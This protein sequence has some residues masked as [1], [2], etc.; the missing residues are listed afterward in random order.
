MTENTTT[1]DEIEQLPDRIATT[2]NNRTVFVTGGSGF[3]GKVLVEKILRKC[4]RVK[5]IYLLLRV[6]KGKAPHQRIHELFSSPVSL[7]IH[8]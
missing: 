8:L 2:F 4:P 6:K 5:T 1:D 3:L 7:L